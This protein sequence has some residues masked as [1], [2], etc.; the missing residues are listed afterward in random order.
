[1]AA[2]VHS[3]AAS[4]SSSRRCRL[5]TKLPLGQDFLPTFFF[6]RVLQ[7]RGDT[8]RN[9]PSGRVLSQLI[10]RPGLCIPVLARRSRGRSRE[11]RTLTHLSKVARVPRREIFGGRNS[12]KVTLD[13]VERRVGASGIT[14]DT[15]STCSNTKSGRPMSW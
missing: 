7:R 13:T 5:V 4:S 3:H 8:S 14:E 6:V 12:R 9:I 10:T 1:V 11:R 2:G 15:S